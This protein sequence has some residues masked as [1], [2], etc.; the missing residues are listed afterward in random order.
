MIHIGKI[1]QARSYLAKHSL[2]SKNPKYKNIYTDLSVISMNDAGTG[3]QRLVK[4][5]WNELLKEP[6]QNYNYIPIYATRK[7]KYAISIYPSKNVKKR[8]YV[9]LKSNDIFFGLDWS[10]DQIIKHQKQLFEWKA[11]GAKLVFIVNDILAL[12]HPEWFT[13]KNKAK[14]E[15]WLKIISVCADQ[16]ICVS[17]TVKSE[18]ETW[19]LEHHISPQQ[20]PCSAIKLGGEI[21]PI[22]P[23]NTVSY[24]NF[25]ERSHKLQP[26]FLKVST[27][28]PRKGHLSVIKAFEY[29]WEKH[30]EFNYNLVLVGKYGWKSEETIEYLLSSPFFDKK[31]FWFNNTNDAQLIELYQ[32]SIGVINASKGEGFGLPLMEAIYYKKPLLIRDL[33]VFREVSQ[34][35]ATYFENDAPDQFSQDILDWCKTIQN[36]QIK[37]ILYQSWHETMLEITKILKS[38]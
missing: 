34:N 2:I 38:L 16:L 4:S 20:L 13:A 27:I 30:P 37:P 35:Q 18:V 19:L 1:S 22:L 15:H 11:N 3:I 29:L 26:F 21:T 17:N 24:Q 5:V 7:K 14:L 28:E 33:P 36:Q 8:N 12:Q 32:Q 9:N 25:F 23:T 10:A 31:V 6:S